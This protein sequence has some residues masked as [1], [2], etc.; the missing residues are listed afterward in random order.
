M[1]VPDG[2]ISGTMHHCGLSGVSKAPNKPRAAGIALGGSVC[3][4]GCRHLGGGLG[5][6]QAALGPFQKLLGLQ[7]LEKLLEAWQ[8]H[9]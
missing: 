6:G 9:S 5:R 7:K 2:D 3:A 4:C 8:Q 1:M